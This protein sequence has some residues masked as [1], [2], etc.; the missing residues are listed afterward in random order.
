MPALALLCSLCLLA[1]GA[2]FALPAFFPVFLSSSFF[3]HGNGRASHHFIT[4]TRRTAQR[5]QCPGQ[6][7]NRPPTTAIDRAESKLAQSFCLIEISFSCFSFGLS[8]CFNRLLPL[9]LACRRYLRRPA[10]GIQ[11][12]KSAPIPHPK[13]KTV[14]FPS[15]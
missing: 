1:F 6:P 10:R 5:K 3:V 14:S 7:L 12:L 2:R 15:F 8:V 13:T 9:C 11:T 4:P